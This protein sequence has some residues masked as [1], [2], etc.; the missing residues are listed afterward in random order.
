MAWRQTI[1]ATANC[2]SVAAAGEKRKNREHDWKQ[3]AEKE[4]PNCSCYPL[5]LLL[6]LCCWLQ[7]AERQREPSDRVGE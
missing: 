5:L 3:K 2:C 1:A 7:L 4:R 6:T